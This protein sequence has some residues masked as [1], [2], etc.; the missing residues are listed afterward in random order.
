VLPEGPSEATERSGQKGPWWGLTWLALRGTAVLA[1]LTK[2]NFLRQLRPLRRVIGGHHRIVV[3]QLPLRAVLLR[4]HSEPPQMPPQR[5]EFAAV[6]QT[7]EIVRCD[8]LADRYRCR[9]RWWFFRICHAV[10]DL[11]QPRVNRF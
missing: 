4:R 5:F 6:V 2:P 7:D 10:P 1:E 3:R 11:H 9:W 8:R